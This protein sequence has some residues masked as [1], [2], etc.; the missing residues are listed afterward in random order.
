[1]VTAPFWV[2]GTELCPPT[3]PIHKSVLTPAGTISRQGLSE[4]IK[5]REVVR[6]RPDRMGRPYKKRLR[7]LSLPLPT[8]LLRGQA[9][10]DTVAP[11][12]PP[13]LDS[14]RTLLLDF[15]PQL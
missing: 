7:E 13:E 3:P 14:V 2:L 5:V 4:V 1:M 12:K 11:Q 10:E 8:S 9:P 15:Q 6:V